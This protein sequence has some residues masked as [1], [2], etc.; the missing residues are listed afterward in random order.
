MVC[1]QCVKLGV[2]ARIRV[3]NRTRPDGSPL[4]NPWAL[5]SDTD[6][7]WALRQVWPAAEDESHG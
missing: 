5:G 2:H 6:V 3:F 4:P 7:E 1:G